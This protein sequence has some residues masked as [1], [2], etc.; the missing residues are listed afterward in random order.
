ML[1]V[2]GD[3]ERD[4]IHCAAGTGE[5]VLYK[6]IKLCIIRIDTIIRVLPSRTV[7]LKFISYKKVTVSFRS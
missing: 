7:A 5:E 3:N 1:E 6:S 4:R 2:F